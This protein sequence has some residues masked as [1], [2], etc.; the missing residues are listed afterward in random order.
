MLV[1]QMLIFCSLYTYFSE[2]WKP[3]NL[4]GSLETMLQEFG[5]QTR[6]PSK[7]ST[8]LLN[9]HCRE[10]ILKNVYCAGKGIQTIFSYIGA[11]GKNQITEDVMQHFPFPLRRSEK[12]H[13]KFRLVRF[14]QHLKFEVRFSRQAQFFV[15]FFL[16]SGM[17]MDILP[18][19]SSP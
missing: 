3:Q 9:Q 16:P 15:N 5:I 17:V 19:F 11:I 10:T 2:P 1:G 12:S 6:W 7:W 8:V 18:S 4:C 14:Y 13:L